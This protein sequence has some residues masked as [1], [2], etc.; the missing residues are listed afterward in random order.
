MSPQFDS[1][2]LEYKKHYEELMQNFDIQHPADFDLHEHYL[3]YKENPDIFSCED[4]YDDQYD[5]LRD[6][7]W[8]MPKHYEILKEEQ[9]KD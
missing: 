5:V 1:E 8:K 9:R 3:R 2:F 4:P 6:Y 7:K